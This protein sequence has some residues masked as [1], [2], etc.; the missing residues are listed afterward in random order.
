MEFKG[1][2]SKMKVFHEDPVSYMLEIG[3]DMIEMNTYLGHHI[4]LIFDGIIHCVACGR[5]IPK[6]YG[7]GFCYPCFQESPLNSECIIRPELC[8]AHLGKGRDPT[9]E[10]EHHNQP[11]V[12]YLAL[13]S[14]V[15][16]GVTRLDQIPD[17]WI[18]QGAWKAIVLAKVPYRQLAGQIEVSIK[19]TMSDKTPW[20]K[21]LKNE[22]DDQVNL[23]DIKYK[24][25]EYL[26]DYFQKYLTNDSNIY[27]FNYPVISY[28][29]KVKSIN[30]LKEP[31]IEGTFTGIRG[32]Y[33]MVDQE[34]VLNI[35]N[36]S[37]YQI[38]LNLID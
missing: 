15:K 20:Q 7:Q 10:L 2:L 29:V 5:R 14:A 25:Q 26:P 35:R 27:E 34:K 8:E 32:Q 31:I 24:V 28:P 17:R 9:W 11:H 13:T 6:V 37:G 3:N 23:S 1:D 22:M 4:S 19:K 30:L 18:D 16:V 38:I 12:V 33:I 21:M 36:H